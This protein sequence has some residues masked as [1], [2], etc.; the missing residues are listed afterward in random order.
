VRKERSN[1]NS[2]LLYTA[3][4]P[5]YRLFTDRAGNAP[6]FANFMA[7]VLGEQGF[8]AHIDTCSE[9]HLDLL[10]VEFSRH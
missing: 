8:A 2:V 5:K 7:T 10:I 9:L 6:S 3:L 1:G 4:V